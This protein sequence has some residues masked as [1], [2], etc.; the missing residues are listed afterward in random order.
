MCSEPDKKLTEGEKREIV[1][2]TMTTEV[3]GM[4]KQ[5]LTIATTILAGT[6]IFLDKIAPSPAKES[7]FYLGLGWLALA[8]SVISIVYIRWNNAESARFYLINDKERAKIREKIN[9]FL[10]RLA[11]LS[12]LVGVLSV[13][14]FEFI[15]LK[16][17]TINNPIGEKKG[18]KAKQSDGGSAMAKK[19]KSPTKRELH[20]ISITAI[21]GP[22]PN[23]EI[24]KPSEKVSTNTEKENEG[25]VVGNEETK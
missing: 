12:L 10:T 13:S 25:E 8:F 4:Y 22:E 16:N 6:L 18:I 1:F 24:V 19:A 7:L 14:F 9:R 5:I 11:I 3:E 23:V 17:K 2:T 20:A 21:D 15:N